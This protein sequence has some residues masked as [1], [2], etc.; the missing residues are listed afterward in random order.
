[1]RDQDGDESSRDFERVANPEHDEPF[2]DETLP[3]DELQERLYWSMK[4]KTIAAIAAYQ[5]LE[6]GFFIVGL[7][8]WPAWPPIGTSR[9]RGRLHE[10][11]KSG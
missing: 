11:K 8:W 9:V 6:R 2:G 7:P 1:M 3:A 5:S 4:A 10:E